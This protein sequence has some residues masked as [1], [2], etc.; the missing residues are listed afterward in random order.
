[1]RPTPFAFLCLILI[2]L[3]GCARNSVQNNV[4]FCNDDKYSS[5]PRLVGQ[6]L[7]FYEVKPIAVRA[8]AFLDEGAVTEAFDP[9]AVSAL[10]T[11]IAKYWYPQYLATVVI[12]VDRGKT[13]VKI[14]SWSDLAVIQEKVGLCTSGTDFQ[15]LMLAMAYGLEVK[16]SS[17]DFTLKS[18]AALLARVQNEKRLV[19]NSFEPPV[20]ICFDYQAAGLIKNGRNYEIIVPGEGTLTFK[21][22]LLSKTELAFI[23]DADTKLLEAGFRLTDG[24]CDSALYPD[25]HAY[26]NADFI[27]DYDHFNTMVFETTRTMRREV[28]HIRLYT[29]ADGREHQYWVLIYIIIM[30]IWLASL[31][32]RIAHENMRRTVLAAGSLLLGWILARLISYQLYLH[33]DLRRYI[34]FTYYLFQL[35]LPVAFMWLAHIID[36]KEGKI[37]APWWMKVFAAYMFTLIALVY[38][39]DLHG[40]V[41]VIDFSN[42]NWGSDYGYEI[43]YRIIQRSWQF[44]L[45]AVFILLLIKSKGFIRVKTIVFPMLAIAV[46]AAYQYGYQNRVPVAW[47][48]D[49]TMVIGLLM[50]LFAESLIRSGMIPVNTKYKTLF[51]NSPLGMR[52]LSA[53]GS[54]VLSSASA[55]P[56]D[57]DILVHSLGTTPVSM[58]RDKDTLL[59]I[60]K[61]TGGYALWREDIGS[62][63]RLNKEIEESV[64]KLKAANMILS[65]EE[66]IKR[67]AQ[68]KNIKTQLLAQ[69]E[70][71]ITEHTI[72][73][74]VLIEQLI[75]KG[76]HE[77][78]PGQQKA[79][80]PIALELCYIKRR[81]NLFFREKEAEALGADELKIYFDEL[82]EIAGYSGLGIIVTGG[83]KTQIS[84][85]CAT[86]LYDFFHSVICRAVDKQAASGENFNI[87]VFLSTENGSA[88]LRLL[89]KQMLVKQIPL[90]EEGRSFE[91]EKSLETSIARAGGIY[92]V[93]DLDDAIG[94]SLSFTEGGK[95]NV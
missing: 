82:A 3:G 93:K 67:A 8:F 86:L 76:Y 61:I 36:K 68:E 40:W 57:K 80:A 55:A 91:I 39:N 87:P 72:K 49:K 78:S 9:N 25:A 26:D 85:R 92:S 23:G 83:L 16:E 45:V 11:N 60:N 65:E 18:A 59:F 17:R 64:A 62:L 56:F 69:L 79:L 48:S 38:T 33:T 4:I 53:E 81:C 84:V 43:V 42:P 13:S 74:S 29:S 14:D 1:M 46:L 47:E 77:N 70:S 27:S 90:S 94:I 22:G 24:R 32:N 35:S 52:I 28:L 21:K 75:S 54:P 41:F 88:V 15:M 20:V 63:N 44:S 50:L 5:Y 95:N 71:E 19:T 58:Q 73:L 10:K 12:A 6:I 34:W 37:A 66:K 89:V 51:N 7:P 30:V 2:S 31:M